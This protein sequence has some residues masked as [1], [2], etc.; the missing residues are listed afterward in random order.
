LFRS[1]SRILEEQYADLLNSNEDIELLIYIL[2]TYIL[3]NSLD[4]DR[5]VKMIT[6]LQSNLTES[7]LLSMQESRVANLARSLKQVVVQRQ[8]TE[9]TEFEKMVS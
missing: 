2:H 1:F 5:I 8:K 3:N 7:E 9:F 6:N 4:N